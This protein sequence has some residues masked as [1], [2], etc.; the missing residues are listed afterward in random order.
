MALNLSLTSFLRL[1]S[2]FNISVAFKI[3]SLRLFSEGLY[4]ELIVCWLVCLS[5][6][7]PLFP[8]ETPKFEDF[9]PPISCATVGL[10]V[11][12]TSTVEN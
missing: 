3:W 8:M 4:V 5:V 9:D 7:T 2:E 10:S 1:S 6:G 12:L 11:G